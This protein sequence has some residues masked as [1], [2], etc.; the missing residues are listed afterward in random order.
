MASAVGRQ[1]VSA[2][3]LVERALDKAE[4][5]QVSTNA[6]SHIHR[7]EA[8]AQ[9]HLRDG[10]IK[11]GERLGLLAG[12]PLVLKDN[13]LQANRPATCGSAMLRNYIAPFDA[14]CVRRLLAAGAIIIGRGN[15]DE[16]G[17]GSSTE[18]C[19]WGEVRNPWRL[20]RVPGGSSGGPAAAVAS[21]VVGLAL[22]SDTGGSARQPGAFTGVVAIKPTYGRISRRGLVAFASST[23]QVAPM[24]RTVRDT[25]LLAR[26]VSGHDQKDQTSLKEAVVDWVTACERPVAGM[27][28]GLPK[29][30]FAI[31]IE[32]GVRS[33]IDS[34]L[35]RLER[36]GA[37][38][39]EVS[40]PTTNLALACYYIL[41]P[42]EAS[43]NLA[44]FD[45]VRFGRR[46]TPGPPAE[47][48]GEFYRRARSRGF[49]TEV[50]RRI[51]VGTHVLS[52]GYIEA[53]Y[54]KA[55]RVRA[56]LA[57]ELGEV[58]G[59]VDV[60]ATPTT[61]HV[62]FEFGTRTDPL[63]MYREDIFTI[64]AS[65]SGIPAISVPCGISQGLPVG[66]QFMSAWCDEASCFT[67]A[68]AVEAT[69]TLPHPNV[70]VL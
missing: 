48:L 8:L 36:L 45:G 3:S 34:T 44:R 14:E 51:L 27:K 25:A 64:P 28:I 11:N 16:F 4:Q 50:K 26:V 9:A 46:L 56:Q 13:I 61:P 7:E 23:D 41:A 59:K 67:A 2:L 5:I 6:F 31:D 21:G 40:L 68:A 47:D 69:T 17:M 70:S 53:Y 15:M 24:A 63:S 60:V 37:Q 1:Q 38:L 35:G 12:V 55:L 54:Q 58:F 29:E 62:A 32:G 65:L 66:L 22:A 49:G 10:S 19:A 30:Y 43:A 20:D 57:H 42:A 39:V 33:A 52:S 18:H